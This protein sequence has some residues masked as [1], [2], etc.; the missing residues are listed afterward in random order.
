MYD[1]FSITKMTSLACLSTNHF[2]ITT[3]C[4]RWIGLTQPGTCSKCQGNDCTRCRSLW[5]WSDGS[6]NT[7]SSWYQYHP[8]R[9]SNKCAAIRPDGKWTSNSCT[10]DSNPAFCKRGWCYIVVELCE[11]NTGDGTLLVW[12]TQRDTCIPIYSLV[13]ELTKLTSKSINKYSSDT[14]EK[15]N[16]SVSLWMVCL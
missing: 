10:T 7:Y 3:C 15:K 8:Y 6:S 13:T 2:Y 16:C 5:Q 14:C 4:R 9:S 1:A 12:R 11:H